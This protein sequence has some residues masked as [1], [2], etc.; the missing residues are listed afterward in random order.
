MKSMQRGQW[1]KIKSPEKFINVLWIYD[2]DYNAVQWEI[3]NFY[4]KY[5][6]HQYA[7]H[8]EK[9]NPETHTSSNPDR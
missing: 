3:N 1:E 9:L 7:I 2:R 4:D 8:V 5:L 6:S